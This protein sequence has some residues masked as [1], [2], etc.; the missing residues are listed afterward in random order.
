VPDREGNAQREKIARWW[1]DHPS[2]RTYQGVTCAPNQETPEFFNLWQGFAVVPKAGAW[3]LLRAH[4]A[5]VICAKV[6]STFR[7]LL[8]WIAAAVQHPEKPAEVAVVLR[9]PQGS[10]KGTFARALGALFGE[11]FIH[12]SRREHLAGHFNAHLLSAIVVFA[13]EAFLAGDRQAEGVLKMLI[14]EPRIP[15]EGKGRDVVFGDN[16]VHLLIASNHDWVIPAGHDERR[17]AV[18]DVAADYAQDH[19]YFAALADELHGGG[20]AAMLHDLLGYDYSG[21]NL[22]QPPMTAGLFDQKRHSMDPAARWWFDRLMTGHILPS[23]YPAGEDWP[24]EIPRQ[25]LWQDYT[26]TIEGIG[27]RSDRA[28]QT[29]LG[30]KLKKFLPEGFPREVRRSM[31]GCEKSVRF[32]GLPTRTECRDHFA[33]TY[34]QPD[35]RWPSSTDQPQEPG[36]RPVVVRLS[37]RRRR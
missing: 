18:L 24:T 22:R 21:V 11:H 30:Q 5:D 34:L 19:R 10:G 31:P 37:R 12:V 13:D 23:L 26:A 29:E 20:L 14:T 35:F 2:R 36:T 1:L 15:I 25:E 4:L 27:T 7:W 17:F 32:Y 9:G 3:P 6:P 8:A 28:T 16:L 33:R